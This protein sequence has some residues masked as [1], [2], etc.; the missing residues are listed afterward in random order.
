MPAVTKTYGQEYPLTFK[1]A[2]IAT[3]KKYLAQGLKELGLQKLPKLEILIND[4]A[5]HKRDAE[6]LQAYFKKALDIDIGI[7]VQTFKVRLQKTTNKEYDIVKA[8]WGPDY[9]DAMTF[10]DLF[11]SWNANNESGWSH[12]EYD[13][14]IKV[15]AASVDAKERMEA[16]HKAEKI[17]VEEAPIASMIQATR[18]YVQNPDL[19]GVIRRTISP[20]PDF[21]YARIN[22]KVAKK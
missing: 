20:D 11:T 7:D 12:P 9:L 21:Y 8:G 6:Y 4:N 3:A 19:V 5:G 16:F 15:A 10:G 1:D 22:E 2:D 13:R 18:V 14:L 17:L